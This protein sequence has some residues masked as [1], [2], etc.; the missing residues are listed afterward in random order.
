MITGRDSGHPSDDQ[1]RRTGEVGPLA[2]ASF[3]QCVR[4]TEPVQERRCRDRVQKNTRSSICGENSFRFVP[5][6]FRS[7]SRSTGPIRWW[8]NSLNREVL[9]LQN[10]MI[11][12]SLE[13]IHLLVL[14]LVR[15]SLDSRCFWSIPAFHRSHQIWNHSCIIR[16][17]FATVKGCFPPPPFR[18]YS[19][20]ISEPIMPGWREHHQP[21]MKSKTCAIEY[22]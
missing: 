3:P 9:F 19:S 13:E 21:H 12:I 22:P 11:P 10:A 5:A 18:L 14:P 1:K 16:E 4:Q 6:G 17:D 20:M 7:H 15:H 8:M 2:P